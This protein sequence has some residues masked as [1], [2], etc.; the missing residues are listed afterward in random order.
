M[1]YVPWS[2][3]WLSQFLLNVKYC[4]DT[5]TVMT[6]SQVIL[7][8]SPG[9]QFQ[10]NLR[11]FDQFLRSVNASVAFLSLTPPFDGLSDS[12]SMAF[13][14]HD[15]ENYYRNG[16][17]IFLVNEPILG[18]SLHGLV[19][20]TGNLWVTATSIFPDNPIVL[21]IPFRLSPCHL[22]YTVED[23]DA[24]KVSK[25]IARVYADVNIVVSLIFV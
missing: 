3:A 12:P 22:G 6:T 9:E 18:I 7:T 4:N 8:P 13:L 11:A 21:S 24:E 19:N 16:S 10:L 25:A 23:V 14:R 2:H 5:Q 1:F 20:A 17:I 15:D